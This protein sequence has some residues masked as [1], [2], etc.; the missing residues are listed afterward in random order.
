MFG[1]HMKKSDLLKLLWSP[2]QRRTLSRKP[3]LPAR[4]MELGLEE[5]ERSVL[6]LPGTALPRAAAMAEKGQIK[7]CR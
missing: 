1:R 7:A 6:S 4:M 5:P 3:D 2:F